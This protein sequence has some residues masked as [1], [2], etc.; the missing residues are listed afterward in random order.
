I[1]EQTHGSRKASKFTSDDVISSTLNDVLTNILNRL[2]LQDAVRT[3]TLLRSW[4]YKWTMINQL[5]FDEDFYKY[6]QKIEKEKDYGRI[7]DLFLRHHNGSVTKFHLYIEKG[8]NSIL[9]VDDIRNW[10]LV[11]SQ[12]GILEFPLLNMEATSLKLKHLEL[13]NCHFCPI[14]SFPGFANLLSLDLFELVFR[15]YTCGEFVQSGVFSNH[16]RFSIRE[17][18][19]LSE[20][21]TS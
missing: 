14:S 9:D 12:K 17:L 2:P 15:S 7:I 13:L 21:K 8:C 18:N 5:I 1:I 11:L 16:R 19:I 10:I 3:G 20:N 6:L 4:R